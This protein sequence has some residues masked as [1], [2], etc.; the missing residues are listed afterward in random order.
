MKAAGILFL[1]ATRPLASTAADGSFQLTL[2]VMD[3]QGPHRVEPWRVTWTG[4]AARAWWGRHGAALAKG[5]PLALE[6]M[7][8]RTYINGR[9]GGAETHA[10]VLSCE[11]APKRWA[12]GDGA[13]SKTEQTV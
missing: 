5:Q 6:L 1:G 7:G 9:F 13:L 11:L 2:L 3:R 10:T 12:G 8:L 4:D